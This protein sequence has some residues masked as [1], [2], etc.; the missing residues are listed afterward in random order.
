MSE[1]K[2]EAEVRWLRD[3]L[4]EILAKWESL[5]DARGLDK[6][7]KRRFVYARWD[8]IVAAEMD[9][10]DALVYILDD[11]QVARLD[12]EWDYEHSVNDV[13][14]AVNL[15]DFLLGEGGEDLDF[16]RVVK[17]IVDEIVQEAGRK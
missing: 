10:Y 16:L 14:T 15:L 1:M 7:K 8:M 12:I 17:K 4:K 13:E 11:R 2:S 9:Y 5:R 6:H 3:A